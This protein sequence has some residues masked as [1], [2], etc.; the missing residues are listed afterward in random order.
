MFFHLSIWNLCF[1]RLLHCFNAE[2]YS[3]SRSINKANAIM[4]HFRL[5]VVSLAVYIAF[6]FCLI[7]STSLHIRSYMAD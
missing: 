7:A 1:S 4:E 6:I 5:S 3:S 2:T